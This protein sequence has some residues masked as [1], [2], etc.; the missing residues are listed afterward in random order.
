MYIIWIDHTLSD[1]VSMV[2]FLFRF[3]CALAC[4]LILAL[5]GRNRL[6]GGPKLGDL[7]VYE[8]SLH[9]V[10]IDARVDRRNGLDEGL[11]ISFRFC[12]KKNIPCGKVFFFIPIVCLRCGLF[13][14]NTIHAYVC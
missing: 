3:L 12:L 6:S 14:L 13:P 8:V 11:G 10:N 7:C 2:I 9:S 5:R 4:Q 1:N